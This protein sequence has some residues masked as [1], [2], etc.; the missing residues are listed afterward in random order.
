MQER[1]VT[2]SL[3]WDSRVKAEAIHSLRLVPGGVR[4]VARSDAG[5]ARLNDGGQGAADVVA[6]WTPLSKVC[7]TVAVGTG[8]QGAR[9]GSLQW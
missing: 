9:S 5:V 8:V 7:G 6:R 3:Q 2:R 1:F 4:E